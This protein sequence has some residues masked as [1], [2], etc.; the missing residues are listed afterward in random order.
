MHHAEKRE[1]QNPIADESDDS[2]DEGSSEDEEGS[3]EDRTVIEDKSISTSVLHFPVPVP[4]TDLNQIYIRGCYDRIYDEYIQ[5]YKNTLIIGNPGVGK[6]YFSF[7]AVYRL[8]ADHP[9]ASIFYGSAYSGYFICMCGGEVQELDP[10]KLQ[11]FDYYVFDCG[12]SESKFLPH[13]FNAGSSTKSIVCSSPDME[14]YKDYYKGCI[15]AAAAVSESVQIYMPIWTWDEVAFCNRYVH[16][17]V[18]M[19]LVEERFNV[20]GGIARQ[21]FRPNIIG[22]NDKEMLSAKIKSTDIQGTLSLVNTET[23]ITMISSQ[24]LHAHPKEGNYA[25]VVTKFASQFAAQ[26]VYEKL[27][28]TSYASVITTMSAAAD[29][30]CLHA[31]YGRIFE[32]YCHKQLP[33]E[34]FKMKSLLPARKSETLALH[35]E[36]RFFSKLQEIMSVTTRNDYYFIPEVSNFPTVNAIAPPDM[37]F[38]MTVSLDHSVKR[39]YLLKIKKALQCSSLNLYFVVPENIYEQ[40]PQQKYFNENNQ[41]CKYQMDWVTQWAVC[42]PIKTNV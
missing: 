27:E 17:N 26:C 20:W 32:S 16:N 42:V 5:K 35:R 39:K 10:Y 21:I 6:T 7:Y 11:C 38:Q 15:V 31:V 28:N 33:S 29:R 22:L 40:F 13:V 30:P 25:S 41:V 2:E 34:Q 3:S 36:R 14:N 9:T 1:Y 18:S 23:P 37:L 8:L 24:I 12:Q 4:N 19:P